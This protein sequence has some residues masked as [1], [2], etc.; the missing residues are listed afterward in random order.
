MFV[1]FFGSLMPM[2]LTTSYG[3]VLPSI[4]AIGT[5]IPLIVAVFLIWYLEVDKTFMKKK[6]RKIGTIVQR[7]AGIF[8][9]LLG[10]RYD[11]LL[12]LIGY[13]FQLNIFKIKCL[14]IEGRHIL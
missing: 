4:F 10:F 7:I 11:H 9:I 6:G 13:Y 12:G 8:L 1:L 5:S 2:V 14:P 3:A